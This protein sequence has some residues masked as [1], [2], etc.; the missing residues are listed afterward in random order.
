MQSL[1]VTVVVILD[2]PC[3]PCLCDAFINAEK[4]L[5]HGT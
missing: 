4:I 2:L 3:G 5:L 1:M